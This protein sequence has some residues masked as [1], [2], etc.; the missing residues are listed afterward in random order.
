MNT[1]K[2]INELLEY[3]DRTSKNKDLIHSQYRQIY[4]TK[5]NKKFW[6][7]F[8]IELEKRKYQGCYEV[9]EL[10]EESEDNR[11]FEL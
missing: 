4:D 9:E 11:Y 10:F 2:N 5:A 8:G 7:E 3:I 6:K 1:I